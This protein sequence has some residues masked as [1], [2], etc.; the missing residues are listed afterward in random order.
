MFGL[1]RTFLAFM[2]AIHH[3]LSIPIIGQYAVHG[4]FILSGYLM[5]YVMHNTY[6]YSLRGIKFF[7]LNRFLRL[8]PIYWIVIILTIFL[9]SIYGEGNSRQYREFIFLPNSCFE[10]FQNLSLVYFDFFPNTVKPRL[11][12]PTWALTIELFFYLLISIGI[13]R[14]KN[15]T[16]LWFSGSIF[17]MACTHFFNL[18]YDYRY[19]SVISGSMAFSLGGIIF[20]FYTNIKSN[21][22]F[23][24][25]PKNIFYFYILFLLNALLAMSLKYFYFNYGLDNICFYN[26][27]LINFVTIV[28]LIDSRYFLKKY[29]Y[30]IGNFSY[31]LY[32]IHWQAGFLA[33]M[34]L[35]NEPLR[36]FNL[37]SIISFTLAIFISVSFSYVIIIF[38]DRP[39]NGM[40]NFLKSINF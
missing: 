16:L 15:V 35:W 4:F 39:I 25:L 20:H 40:R 7:I 22:F 38:V 6:G 13:S 33:S 27:I 5:T 17:Y 3:L 29:D 26:N 37:H 1:Y 2:V 28:F 8:Y 23:R 30:I 21:F 31:P 9:I 10:W 34:I 24:L 32:L 19:F 18:G 12:P 14:S 36:G 11:S